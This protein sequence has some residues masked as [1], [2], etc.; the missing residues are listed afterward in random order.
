MIFLYGYVHSDVDFVSNN[1]KKWNQ[2]DIGTI[3]PNVATE[4]PK[5]TM[6]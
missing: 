6:K 1:Q 4:I 2:Y 5:I 3:L